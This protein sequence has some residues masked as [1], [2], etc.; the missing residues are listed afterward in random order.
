MML[1]CDMNLNRKSPQLFAK[2]VYVPQEAFIESHQALAVH[3]LYIIANHKH[4]PVCL[5]SPLAS[6][7]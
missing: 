6:L 2:A 7:Y 1:N 5:H 4:L 3:A